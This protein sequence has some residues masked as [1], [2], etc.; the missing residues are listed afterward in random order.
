MYKVAELASLISENDVTLN[1]SAAEQ[2]PGFVGGHVRAIHNDRD[3]DLE[4]RALYFSLTRHEHFS[5]G[6][7]GNEKKSD[8]EAAVR[9]R[10]REFLLNQLEA[11]ADDANE[12]CDPRAAEA[13]IDSSTEATGR[14]Y[15]AYVELRKAGAPREY[16]PTR[17]HA[18]N[19]LNAVAPTKLVD[20]AWLYG[21]TAHWDDPRLRPLQR[22]YLEELGDG[23]AALNHVLLYRQ[24]LDQQDCDHPELLTASH[25][26]QGAVQLALAYNADEFL[27]EI[28]GFNLGYEQLPLHLLITAYELRE[29]GIDPYYFTL[30][31]TIDNSH[32][33][34]A[35]KAFQ[36]LINM[37]PHDG[38]VEEFLRRVRRGAALGDSGLS[39]SQIIESFDLDDT[40]LRILI[41]KSRIGKYMHGDYCRVGGRTVSD[42]L[43]TPK[44]MPLFLRA[45]E[46]S[47][48]IKRGEPAE[49]SRFWRLLHGDKARMFGVFTNF[50][51]QVLRDWISGP[52]HDAAAPRHSAVKSEP[53]MDLTGD[54]ERLR[55]SLE[56]SNDVGVT[57][58]RLRPWL[59]PN[60]HH[61]AAGLLATRTFS[62][63]LA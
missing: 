32:A 6:D 2:I 17:S 39:S 44:D 40:L 12:L 48:W 45:L 34:H 13:C 51:Q 1:P 49:N 18:L 28:I 22:I 52:T 24:L 54:C 56:K 5:N 38:D 11:V 41:D 42:W 37:L 58:K 25:Y 33:G 53:A 15:R 19:F 62:R 14:Q 29:L 27:P 31:I 7:A 59:A 30:H 3:D 63:L 26:R 47:G 21:L 23:D 10:S 61:T 4:A 57:L 20:G 46:E 36:G 16:F 35:R 50:E 55:E 43:G 8:E 9:A 60:R